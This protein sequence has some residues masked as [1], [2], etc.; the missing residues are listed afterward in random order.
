MEPG[1]AAMIGKE[2]RKAAMAEQNEHRTGIRAASPETSGH[3]NNGMA[4]AKAMV[5]EAAM[6][7]EVA[8]R[9]GNL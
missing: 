1:K 4:K 3:R 7:T 2:P 6:V 8:R 9:S 5:T